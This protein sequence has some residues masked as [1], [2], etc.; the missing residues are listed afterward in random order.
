MYIDAY[1]RTHANTKVV[2]QILFIFVFFALCPR[3]VP[4]R[5]GT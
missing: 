2:S 1:M 4:K 5:V 3:Y